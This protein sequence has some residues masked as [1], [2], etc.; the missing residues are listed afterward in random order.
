MLSRHSPV[1]FVN[2]NN[3]RIREMRIRL[4]FLAGK[5]AN[6]T[7]NFFQEAFG[8]LCLS[9]TKVF[10]WHKDFKEGRDSAQQRPGSGHPR[11]ARDK[12]KC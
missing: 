2:K 5:T 3:D 11:E 9:R 1:K 10:A 7:H 8:D 4:F 12:K 6:E